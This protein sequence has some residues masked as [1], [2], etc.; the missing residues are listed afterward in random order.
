MR[1]ATD[2][3]GFTLVEVLVAASLAIVVFGATMTLLGV[4]VRQTGEASVRVDSQDQVRAVVDR[5][6]RDLRNVVAATSPSPATLERAQGK[7]LVFLTVGSGGAS[8]ANATGLRRVRYCLDSARADRIWLQQQTWS[9]AT[10]P[11]W[12]SAAAS[13]PDSAWGQATLLADHVTNVSGALNRPVWSFQY[14]PPSSSAPQDL[15]AVTST[16]YLDANADA[17]PRE[18]ELRSTVYLRNVNGPPIAFFTVAQAQGVLI[19][20]ASPS[21]DPEGH[22]LTYAWSRDGVVLPDTGPRLRA[23]GLSVGSQ[24]TFTLTVVDSGGLS[25]QTTQTVTVQ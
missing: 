13:C 12:P 20:D 25:S 23:G 4:M 18:S 14:R 22:P 11:A 19:L 24:Y 5:L 7:D 10:P 21:N 1:R 17:P 9:T 2:E 8:G 3:R 15:A 16:V 6:S